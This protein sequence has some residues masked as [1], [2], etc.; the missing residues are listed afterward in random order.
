MVSISQTDYI[1]FISKS[2]TSKLTKV[3]NLIGRQ[4][5]HPSFDFY[6]KLRD[7]IID[8]LKSGKKKHELLDFV[9]EE[10]TDRKKLNRY[11][12]LV[13]GLSRFLGRKKTLWF[14]PP[15]T[16][17]SHKDLRIKMNPELGLDLNGEKFIIKLYFKDTSLQRKDIKVL[18]WMMNQSLSKGIFTGYKCALLDVEKGKFFSFKEDV[19]EIKLLV[20]G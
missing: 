3:L 19:S 17:W 18:L 5:Y 11:I 8:N 9:N 2:G 1:D 6:K 4:D 7:T 13:E 20:E 14:D 10:I 12:T 15:T 16:I